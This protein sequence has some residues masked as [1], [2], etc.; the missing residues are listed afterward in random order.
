MIEFPSME[1]A[2]AWYESPEYQEVLP[3]RLSANEDKMVMFEG[4]T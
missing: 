3:I 1:N 2:R 4:L